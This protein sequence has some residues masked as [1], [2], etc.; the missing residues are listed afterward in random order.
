MW[1]DLT[2]MVYPNALERFSGFLVEVCCN[3]ALLSGCGLS[4][5]L[6]LSANEELSKAFC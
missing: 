6:W 5:T 2:A 4:L 3:I 1:P